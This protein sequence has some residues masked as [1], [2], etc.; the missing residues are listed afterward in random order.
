[1]ISGTDLLTTPIA[2]LMTGE[3]MEDPLNIVRSARESQVFDLN[4]LSATV[5]PKM[6]SM[7]QFEK[8]L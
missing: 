4:K 1:M 7:K 2:S 6:V 5:I 3:S 8:E